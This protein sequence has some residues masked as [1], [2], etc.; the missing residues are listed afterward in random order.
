M[1]PWGHLAAGYLLY[2][3]FERVLTDHP[4]G[5]LATIWLV[6]GTQLP[7]LIDKPLAWTLQVLP[8]GRSFGHSLLILVPL[9]LVAAYRSS[10]RYRTAI[11]ALGTGHVT[12]LLGDIVYPLTVGQIHHVGFLGWPLIPPIDYPTTQ[13]FLAH[14]MGIDLTPWFTGQLAL[15]VVAIV[16]WT[17]D[18]NPG[19]RVFDGR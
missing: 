12:H 10:G 7:D 11:V 3:A 5:D 1:W 15:V 4:P 2:T 18:G 6:V 19:L 16:V 14:L 13:S 17:V 8:S 9:L